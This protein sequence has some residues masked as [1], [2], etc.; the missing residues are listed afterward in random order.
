[1]LESPV[2][3]HADVIGQ[4]QRF[5]LIMGDVHEGRAEGSL[6]LLELDFHVLAQLQIERS[7]GL[8]QQQ[9]GRLQHQA[10]CDGDALPLA[11]RQLIDALVRGIAQSHPLQHRIAALDSFRAWAIPRRASPKATFSLTDIMGNNASC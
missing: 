8:V 9:Q 11:A 3:H 4:H 2:T 6:Q 1:M 7:Q 5:G 10:A